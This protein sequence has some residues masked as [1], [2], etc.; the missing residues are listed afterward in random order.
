M[1]FKGNIKDFSLIDVIQLICQSSKSG[2]MKIYTDKF[3]ADIYIKDGKL[4]DIKSE[5]A[6]FSFKIGNYLVTRGVITGADLEVYLEKQKKK[7]IR[8]GQL[9]VEEGVIKKDDIRILYADNIKNNFTKILALESGKYNFISN[10]VEYNPDDT[11][12]INIDTILLDTLKNIDEI[13]LFKKKIDDFS[14]IYVKNNTNKDVVIDKTKATADEPVV[15]TKNSIILNDLSYLVYSMI[16]GVNSIKNLIDKTAL[17]E[18]MVLKILFMLSENGEIKIMETAVKKSDNQDALKI[19]VLTGLFALIF[20]VL[21]V[22]SVFKF[23]SLVADFRQTNFYS[24]YE[25]ELIKS[26]NYELNALESILS[27]EDKK[28]KKLLLECK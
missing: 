9:L 24:E 16:D 21:L 13:K 28:D 25:K 7:P 23:S 4:V 19:Y 20:T 8:L 6:D 15:S 26:C 5:N 27:D 22:S 14:I 1:S 17:Q 3:N 12:P 10:V 18:H 11:I 2:I